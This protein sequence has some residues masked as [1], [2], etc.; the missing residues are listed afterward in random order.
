MFF[1]KKKTFLMAKL[2]FHSNGNLNTMD[3]SEIF[4][5]ISEIFFYTLS[6]A[7]VMIL[8]LYPWVLSF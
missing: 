4:P 2:Q 5:K 7:I 6:S 8:W 3:I 1:V